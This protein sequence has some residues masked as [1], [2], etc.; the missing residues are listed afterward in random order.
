MSLF[1]E[2]RF[3]SGITYCLHGL[4][5]LARI[6]NETERAKL[7][8]RQCLQSCEQIGKSYGLGCMIC[9]AEIFLDEQDSER[10]AR[11]LGALNARV[12]MLQKCFMLPGI[13]A[14]DLTFERALTAARAQLG[15]DAFAVAFA[16][17]QRMSF[18]QAVAYALADAALVETANEF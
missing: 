3:K 5:A 4:A 2:L 9:L 10:A 17:G 6:H 18:D 14:Y 11:L 7:L 8:F 12:E 1:S 16:E 15:E 13:Y